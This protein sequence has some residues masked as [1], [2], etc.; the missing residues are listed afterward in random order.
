[1]IPGFLPLRDWLCAAQP[2][3]LHIFLEFAE[4]SKNDHQQQE[5][6]Q[7]AVHVILEGFAVAEQDHQQQKEEQQGSIV[8]MLSFYQVVIGHSN[9]LP[10]SKSNVSH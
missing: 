2:I 3:A 1:V 8:F 7:Q 5:E 9:N 6:E 10:L 4:F